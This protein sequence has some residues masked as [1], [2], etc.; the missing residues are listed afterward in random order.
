MLSYIAMNM[1]K[2]EQVALDEERAPQPM[3]SYAFVK[4]TCIHT[5]VLLNLYQLSRFNILSNI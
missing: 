5:P 2:E 3:V 4:H 1:R